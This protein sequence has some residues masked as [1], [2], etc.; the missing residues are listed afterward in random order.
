MICLLFELC[1]DRRETVEHFMSRINIAVSLV[2]STFCT[3]LKR[4]YNVL[5]QDHQ[6][7]VVFDEEVYRTTRQRMIHDTENQSNC[8]NCS[9]ATSQ[10]QMIR[11][12]WS[13][14][15]GQCVV[16]KTNISCCHWSRVRVHCQRQTGVNERVKVKNH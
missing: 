15:A 10:E 12:D 2:Q 1:V 4:T 13:N 6:S 7:L 9:A 14:D 8:D 11:D 3:L 5:L 16:V